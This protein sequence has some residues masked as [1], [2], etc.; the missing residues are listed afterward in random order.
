MKKLP[1][2]LLLPLLG[3]GCMSKPQPPIVNPL[4]ETSDTKVYCQGEGILGSKQIAM[5]QNEYCIHSN[6]DEIFFRE[7]KGIKPNTS[8]DYSFEVVDSKGNIITDFKEMYGKKMHLAIVRADLQEF[9]HVTP[10]FNATTNKFMMRNVVLPTDGRYRV[11]AYF[12]PTAEKS[13]V[14]TYETISVGDIS[15]FEFLPPENPETEKTIGNNTFKMTTNPSPLK[16]NQ[17]S[18]ITVSLTQNGK[19]VNIDVS[20]YL[21]QIGPLFVIKQDELTFVPV[22]QSAVSAAGTNGVSFKINFPMSGNYKVFLDY[23]LVGTRELITNV[24]EVK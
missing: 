11:I 5:N 12:A 7:E 14:S 1:F 21:P 13:A 19:P 6:S 18:T 8:F 17:D 2:L 23:P 4:V 20:K 24:I 16:A 22:P 10:E 3:A 9:L 15:K